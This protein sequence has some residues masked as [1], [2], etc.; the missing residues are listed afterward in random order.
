VNPSIPVISIDR[1]T[2]IGV[3][4]AFDWSALGET[5]PL[6]AELDRDYRSK[7][8]KQRRQTEQTFGASLMRL[9]TRR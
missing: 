7:L 2:P 9:R 4:P 1:S 3:L 8:K 5:L 6:A